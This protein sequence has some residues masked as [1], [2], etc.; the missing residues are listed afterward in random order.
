[1]L[2]SLL[3]FVELHGAQRLHVIHVVQVG[4]G[5]V[6]GEWHHG[7][8]SD[9]NEGEREVMPQVTFQLDLGIRGGV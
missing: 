1:M 4:D 7:R 2:K 9:C 6:K 8:A 3:Y 5:E